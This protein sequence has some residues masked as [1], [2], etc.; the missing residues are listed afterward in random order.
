MEEKAVEK[1]TALAG[2]PA[3][4]FAAAKA[5]RVERIRER[6][7]QHCQHK[8]AQLLECWFSPQAQEILT[9]TAKKF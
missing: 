3:A 7:E 1:I 5:T 2:M 4:A 6:Y 8:T 9:E